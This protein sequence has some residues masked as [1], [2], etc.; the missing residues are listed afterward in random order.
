MK[1]LDHPDSSHLRASEGWV[2]LGDFTSAGQE[3]D[4]ISPG[5][6]AHPDVLQLRWR[7]S[8]GAENW[9]ACLDIATTLTEMVPE[10]RFGW[11][12]R[13]QSLDKLGRTSE[14]K[15]LLLSVAKN[16]GATSTLPL[17][18]ARYSCVL[19]QQDEALRWLEKAVAAAN[20]P[21]EL[22]RLRRQVL[23]DPALEPLRKKL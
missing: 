18:L 9:N 4:Q 11:I 7:I 22:L 23:E 17:H 20:N 3:L 13:A 15:D 14:A 1:P 6:R 5:N 10:R 8:A 19:G 2:G 16:F 12:H 21:E